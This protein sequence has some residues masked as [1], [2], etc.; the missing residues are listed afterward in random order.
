MNTK[1]MVGMGRE[2]RNKEDN[3]V[4]K[5]NSKQISKLEANYFCS[6]L[7]L[8]HW[9]GKGKESLSLIPTKTHNA[10]SPLPLSKHN[11]L[12]PPSTIIP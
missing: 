10:T 2:Q 3:N 4:L 11:S 5:L 7:K 1:N 8:H 12:S 6:E 9:L